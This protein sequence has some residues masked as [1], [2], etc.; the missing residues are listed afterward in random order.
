M[1]PNPYEQQRTRLERRGCNRCVPW[2]GSL[3]LT[4]KP[5]AR[6]AGNETA[7][8]METRS[9][10]LKRMG[11]VQWSL[12]WASPIRLSRRGIKT[13]TD[14]RRSRSAYQRDGAA[15][16]TSRASARSRPAAHAAPRKPSANP[17]SS[18]KG[19]NMAYWSS[20]CGSIRRPG[21]FRNPR[22]RKPCRK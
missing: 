9:A 11:S 7:V 6:D 2:A 16:T 13:P 3:S 8:T 18:T 19:V 15:S 10:G 20:E 17:L 4:L 22:W 5:T 1:T 21:L 12:A 14:R